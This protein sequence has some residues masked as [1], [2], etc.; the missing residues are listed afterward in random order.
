MLKQQMEDL[1][2]SDP[3]FFRLKGL[4]N[5]DEAGTV[6]RK[7]GQRFLLL[8]FKILFTGKLFSYCAVKPYYKTFNVTLMGCFSLWPIVK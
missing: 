4:R 7:D 3:A 6:K 2:F 8:I 5:I 1:S